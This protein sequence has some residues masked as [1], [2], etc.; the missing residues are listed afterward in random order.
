M[1]N[2]VFI[3]QLFLVFKKRKRKENCHVE[4]SRM[5]KVSEH[6]ARHAVI[7]NSVFGLKRPEHLGTFDNLVICGEPTLFS[8]PPKM[9]VGG[10]YAMLLPS[11]PGHHSCHWC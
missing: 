8:E 3:L 5:M 7:L 10:K 11:R 4:A 9:L 2:T 1:I 6:Y